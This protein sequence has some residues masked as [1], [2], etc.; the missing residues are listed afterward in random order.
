MQ[1]LRWAAYGIKSAF[2]VEKAMDCVDEASAKMQC[3]PES[4]QLSSWE[5]L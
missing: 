1:R 3:L 2:F 4:S 5:K